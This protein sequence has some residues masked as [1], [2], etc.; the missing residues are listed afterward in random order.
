MHIAGQIRRSLSSSR[1]Q[2]LRVTYQA[3]PFSCPNNDTWISSRARELEC[4]GGTSVHERMKLD[5][6]MRSRCAAFLAGAFAALLGCTASQ[7]ST[8]APQSV[9]TARANFPSWFPG[10]WTREWI[11]RK[12]TRTN[13]FD[14]HFLQTPSLFGDLRIPRDRP[15]FPRATSFADLSDAELLLLARQRGFAGITTVAGALATWHH[16]IDF[17]PP[18][19]TEDI[20]RLERIDD[21]QMYEHALDGSYIESWRSLSS[22]QGRFLAVRVERAGRL[23]RVFLVVG[24]HFLYVRNREKDLPAAESLGSLI[25]ATRATRAQMIEYLNCEFSSG[26]VHDGSIPWEIERSTLPWR[27]GKP[28]DF[29][30]SVVVGN[31]ESLV[32]RVASTERWSVPVNTF[33]RADLVALFPSPR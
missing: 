9:S 24:D 26:R 13:P 2:Q 18:D 12:G 23:D 10:V 1:N 16:E 15:S 33:A 20:G 8:L 30:D 6:K 31:A 7:P 28:L 21:S 19:G 27:E 17:Q 22:G 25:I 29:V 32:P 14:V 11:E 4:R 3:E 5:G